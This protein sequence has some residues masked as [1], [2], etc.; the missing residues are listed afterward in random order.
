MFTMLVN[1]VNYLINSLAT[2]INALILLLP[3]SPFQSTT[4]DSAWLSYVN[5]VIPIS[6]ILQHIALWLTAVLVYYLIRTA[7][8]WGKVAGS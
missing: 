8:R 7:L 3:Q 1:L 2:I 4:L 5:Y 6:S